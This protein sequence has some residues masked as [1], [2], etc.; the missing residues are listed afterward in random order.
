MFY[1]VIA[2]FIG[3]VPAAIASSKGHNFLLWWMYG[4]AL[5]V[6]ALPHSIMVGAG[7]PRQKCPF[8]G[9]MVLDSAAI[10]PHCRSSLPLGKC[11][12]GARLE[13]A[14][15]LCPKCAKAWL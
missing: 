7:G 14:E 5:F 4:A 9:E 2:V 6:V 13:G 12:C 10:C 3:L 8:C 1:V 11:M 15:R